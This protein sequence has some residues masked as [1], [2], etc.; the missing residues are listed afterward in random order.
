MNMEDEAFGNLTRYMMGLQ[1]DIDLAPPHKE[2]TEWLNDRVE[3]L[4]S[5][6]RD[7]LNLWPIVPG[8]GTQEEM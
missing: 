4:R 8:R 2:G 6:Y 3:S 5:C 7:L 1:D